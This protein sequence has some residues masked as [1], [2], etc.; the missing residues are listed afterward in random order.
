V[1]YLIGNKKDLNK[2]RV[3]DVSR[4]KEKA[5]KQKMNRFVEVSAKTN[6]NLMKT[7]E[8]FYME[9]YHRNK[10]KVIEKKNKNLKAYES[11]QKQEVKSC[12]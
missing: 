4:G 7:F 11:F 2:N 5:I 8:E 1:I 3:V 12:C 10:D 9:I 6:E